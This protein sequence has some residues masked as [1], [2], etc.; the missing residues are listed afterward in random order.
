M[1]LAAESR[2]AATQAGTSRDESSL[3]ELRSGEG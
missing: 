1:L 2:T 3:R